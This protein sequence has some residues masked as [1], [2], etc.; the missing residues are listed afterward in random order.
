M[1]GHMKSSC[2][3]LLFSARMANCFWPYAVQLSAQQQQAYVLGYEWN[4]PVFG[5]LVAVWEM[6]SKDHQSLDHRKALGRFI[7]INDFAVLCQDS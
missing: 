1:V 2:R 6:H 3:R 7:M 4:L 5:E